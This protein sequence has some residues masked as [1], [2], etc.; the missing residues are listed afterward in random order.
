MSS[1]NEQFQRLRLA[2]EQ[3]LGQ[4]KLPGGLEDSLQEL[5]VLQI[6]L[7]LQ[8]DELFHANE[9]LELQRLRFEHIY[10]LAPVGYFILDRN[11]V[12]EE[13]N[14]AGMKLL[15][16]G[17]ALI[18]G[19]GLMTFVVPEEADEFH[20]FY[21]TLL[22][23]KEKQRSQIRFRTH[24]GREFHALLDGRLASETKCYIAI[25]DVTEAIEARTRLADTKDRLA[26][27]LEASGAGTWE[28]NLPSMHLNLDE[29]NRLLFDMGFKN[30]YNSF[31]DNV[32]PEDRFRVDQHFRTA[33][34]QDCE[35]DLVTRLLGDK[36][37]FAAI[38]GHLVNREQ[39]ITG[40]M[41][42]VTE[43]KRAD[44]IAQKNI[45]TATLQAEEK[46]R[47]RI[48]ETLH[49]SVAQLLYGIQLNIDQLEDGKLEAGKRKL[50]GLLNT[51]IKQTRDISY[52]LAPPTLAELGLAETIEELCERLTTPA[53][54]LR[55]VIS[56]F[57]SRGDLM[58]ETTLFR[59]TQELIN[60]CL[61][62]SGASTVTVSFK[63]GQIMEI[64]VQDNGQGFMPHELPKSHGAGLVSIRNRL[65]V[66][67]G[68][69]EIDSAPGQ[70]TVARVF[71]TMNG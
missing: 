36:P 1:K 35:I 67:N 44:E 33:I 31:L 39:R 26:M 42:D 7:E 41:W 27:A 14:S 62:H 58:L 23:T 20:R 60:N 65:Q 19:V 24:S 55:P 54:T 51:A 59:I 37:R 52:E 38:R 21:R 18:R 49:D 4:T 15:E 17:K 5:Q 32:H 66:Y 61:K 22:L 47:L 9:E 56:G 53:L 68:T 43:Q 13:V 57:R 34:N 3:A 40:I 46:E 71:I 48:S 70:G 25:I 69:L 28:L 29:S 6:E 11:G 16:T 8:N 64:I 2:A 50:N 63:Q 12:I 10:D 30:S 45:A